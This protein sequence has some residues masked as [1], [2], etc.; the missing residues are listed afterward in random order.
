MFE[1]T[2][3]VAITSRGKDCFGAVPEG[4]PVP[5]CLMHLR[6]AFQFYA[7]YLETVEE[8]TDD[9]RQDVAK[10]PVRSHPTRSDRL[11]VVYYIRIG[12]HIKI[13][14]TADF[15]SRMS[16]L[17]P[18]EILAV[19]LGDRA[20]ERE[21]QSQF[22]RWRAAK[23]REYFEPSPELMEHIRSLPVIPGR[24]IAPEPTE[25]T[26][27]FVAGT[28]CPSCDLMALHRKQAHGD[29]VCLAC[30]AIAPSSPAA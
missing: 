21:R 9:V 11:S 16:T 23:G 25:P 28:P 13:G 3:C 18:D 24:P 30:G 7:D 2:T 1:L 4:A 6:A 10:M 19:E 12:N 15:A 14:T 27:G 20:L 17:Q 26:P 22:V 8:D 5:M 29:A